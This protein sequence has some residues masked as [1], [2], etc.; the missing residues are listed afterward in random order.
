MLAGGIKG[1]G[2][3]AIDE[4]TLSLQ[5][6]VGKALFVTKFSSDIMG[7]LQAVILAIYP[8]FGLVSLTPGAHVKVNVLYVYILFA[9]YSMPFAW[10]LVDLLSDIAMEGVSFGNLDTDPI[11]TLEALG[12]SLIIVTVGTWVALIGL[13]VA[14]L[15]PVRSAIGGL[16]SSVRGT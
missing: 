2:G 10:S 11:G 15:I 13:A 6:L 14:I 3:N 9:I 8:F 16:V 4:L 1:V 7:V 12:S 5:N